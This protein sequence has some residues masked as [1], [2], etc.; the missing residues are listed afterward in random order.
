MNLVLECEKV[1]LSQENLIHDFDC[2]DSDINDFFNND[3]NGNEFAF[4]ETF[5]KLIPKP[6]FHLISCQGF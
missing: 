3:A 4:Y 5:A 1:K 6:H 2:G